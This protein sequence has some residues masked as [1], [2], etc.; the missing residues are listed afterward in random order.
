MWTI[1]VSCKADE[2]LDVLQQMKYKND[3]LDFTKI[4]S[5]AL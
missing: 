3:K 4:K 2:K 5:F 1:A